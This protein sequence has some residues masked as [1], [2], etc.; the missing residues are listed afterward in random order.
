LGKLYRRKTMDKE[1]YS[2]EDGGG[3]AFY[4]AGWAVFLS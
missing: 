1:G 4:P 3:R 2:R